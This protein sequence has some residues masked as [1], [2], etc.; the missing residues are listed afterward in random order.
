MMA[1]VELTCASF[2]FWECAIDVP[3]AFVVLRMFINTSGISR[4]HRLWLPVLID[5]LFEVR[6]VRLSSGSVLDLF[7]TMLLMVRS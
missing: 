7:L 4:E 2:A 5:A 6:V 3:S 1:R